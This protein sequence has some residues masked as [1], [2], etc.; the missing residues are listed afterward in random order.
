VRLVFGGWLWVRVDTTDGS[1]FGRWGR[2]GFAGLCGQ[3]T[4]L[5]IL[6]ELGDDVLLYIL[7]S[8]GLPV[9]QAR[10]VY[11]PEG[12]VLEEVNGVAVASTPV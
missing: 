10:D 1:G 11:L 9:L 12:L 5:L 6:E 8:V 3:N 2:R 7:A 4:L